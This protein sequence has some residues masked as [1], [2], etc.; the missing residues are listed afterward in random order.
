MRKMKKSGLVI[1]VLGL[2][3]GLTG[4]SSD[5]QETAPIEVVTTIE[6]PVKIEFWHAM[7]GAFADTIAEIVNDFNTGRGK[8]LGIT[9]EA[10]YQG[11]YDDLNSKTIAAIKAK[12][13][14][15]VV[16]GTSNSIMEL[17]GSGA[18]Q[19]LNDYVFHETVGMSDYDDIYEVYRK[20]GSSFDEEG[21]IYG[22][23]FSKST[24]LYFYNKEFFDAHGLTV[25][26]TWDELVETSKQITT[27]TKKPALGIDNLPNYFITYLAQVG[28]P[29]T[30]RQGDVLFNHEISLEILTDLKECIDGG[31]WRIGGEDIYHSGPFMSGLV[32]SYIGSTA[33][34]GYLTDEIEWA[35]APIPQVNPEQPAYIQQ[36]N[37]VSVLNQ[38]STNEEVYAAYEFVKYLTGYEAGLKWAQQTGYLPLRESIANSEAYLNHLDE[39]NDKVKANGV[40][41]IKHA[42]VEPLFVTENYLTSNHVRNQV[43]VMIEEILLTDVSIQET[44]DRYESKLK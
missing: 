22:L 31:Y 13:A 36:G 37:I 21:T 39:T 29:Y 1:S 5:K 40:E 20:E 12:K 2:I 16:Q 24:D 19:P 18:V 30:N 34:A 9:V 14:P 44:L 6:E 26:K 43:G 15:Q 10:V 42:F 38:G 32:M 28:A 7:S 4:C 8:E 23:P 27:I 41:S 33:G 17:I 11:S 25:P 3:F 35:T